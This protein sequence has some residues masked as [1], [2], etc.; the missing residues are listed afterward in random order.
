MSDMILS[1]GNTVEAKREFTDKV[2]VRLCLI[3]KVKQLVR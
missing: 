2:T 1:G 3:L